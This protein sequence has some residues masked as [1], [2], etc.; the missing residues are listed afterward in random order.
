LF[1]AIFNVIFNS[2][3]LKWGQKITELFQLDT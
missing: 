1:D 2:K 3:A